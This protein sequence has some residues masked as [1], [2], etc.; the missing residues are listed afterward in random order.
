[1]KIERKDLPKSIVEL[2]IE[3]PTN[4]VAKFRKK[5]VKHLIDNADIKGFRKG[6]VSEAVIVKNY[7]EDYISQMTV[8][9]AIDKVYRDALKAEKLMPVAQGEIKEVISQNPMKIKMEVEV[10]PEITISDDYKKISLKKA[11]VKV[12]AIEVKAALEDIET[13]FTTFKEAGKSEKVSKNDKVTINTQGFDSKGKELANTKME[14]YPLSMGQGVLVPGFEEG[15]VGAKNGD[16]LTLDIDFPKDY[17]N[18][19]F[20]GLKTKFDVEILKIEKAV[21][22]EFTLEF[23][24]KLRGKKLD[25]DGFKKL[26]KTE[27]L[28]V[29]E[30]NV[31]M[32]EES[33]LIEELLKITKIDLGDKILEE[34]IGK[35]F[36]EIKQNMSQDNVIMK[37]YLESLKMDEA[38]L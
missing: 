27:L 14:E 35:V 23:I 38:I 17:H 11:D 8:D 22:P 19:E 3:V 20:A 31:R 32:E 10:F 21:K 25:L 26:I 30:S 15:I 13:K 28:D 5:A 9:F 34:Q 7:G 1:M 2:I 6:H 16:K 24:E 12:S 18:A 4:D 36:E 37:D 33:K 29:K